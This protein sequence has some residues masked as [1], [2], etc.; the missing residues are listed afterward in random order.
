MIEPSRKKTWRCCNRGRHLHR[1]RESCR[2]ERSISVMKKFMERMA[3]IAY[4][5]NLVNGFDTE[6]EV[7]A[8][9]E[10]C[11]AGQSKPLH[12]I[13]C[14]GFFVLCC[15]PNSC[16]RNYQ[17]ADIIFLYRTH[18]RGWLTHGGMVKFK[19][20]HN[21]FAAKHGTMMIKIQYKRQVVKHGDSR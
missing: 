8:C 2:A 17:P 14:G 18:K 12:P 5:I 20:F 16:G 4:S 9:A 6:V 15:S 11:W 13:G 1:S 19:W 10:N 7:F 21:A 3:Q